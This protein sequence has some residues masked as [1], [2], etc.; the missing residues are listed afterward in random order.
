MLR[1]P[2]TADQISLLGIGFSVLAACAL[3]GAARWPWAFL[4]AAVAIQLRLLCNMLDG[5]VAVEGQRSSFNGPLFNEV[6]DRLEDSIIIVAFGHAAGV[7]WLGFTTRAGGFARPAAGFSRPDG[8][9]APHGRLDAGLHRR[10]CRRP[11]RPDGLCPADHVG[12]G[13]S[14]STADRRPS[15]SCNI[16]PAS[17]SAVV[18]ELP[19]IALTRFLVGGHPR[20]QGAA[21]EDR[22]RI[23]FANHGSHLDT[24]LLWAALPPELRSKT[25]PVAA[26]DYWG[27]SALRRFIA[28]HLLNSIFIDRG[29]PQKPADALVPLKS[30][31]AEGHSLIIFPEGTRSAGRFPGPFKSGLYHLAQAVPEAELVPVYLE[32]LNRAFPKGAYIPVPITCAV[33]FGMPIS[34]RGGEERD[35]FLDRARAAIVALG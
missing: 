18:I 20:W 6:P 3:V 2:I 9:A 1:T 29:G 5:L 13:G 27:R 14:G 16:V 12:A 25:H 21:P 22:L 33:R 7:A 15:P 34:L 32:N 35:A 11:D 19:L 24:I 10:V 23:Y 28:Q 4:A 30:K 31:L 26:L 17:G 8:K